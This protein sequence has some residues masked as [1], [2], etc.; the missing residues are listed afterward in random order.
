[1]Q[2]PSPEVLS[3]ETERIRSAASSATD[4]AARAELGQFLT[5]EPTARLM[6]GMF[7]AAPDRLRL[8][9]PG[10]GSGS[11]T[12]A[13][14]SALLARLRPPAA[15]HATLYEV[16]ASILPFL[17]ETLVLC[18]EAARQHGCA[19]TFEVRRS[20]FIRA[21]LDASGSLFGTPERYD[22]AVINP[23]YGKLAA[24]SAERTAMRA[25][26][27]DAPNL[28]AAFVVLAA[29]LLD[30]GGEL[31]AITPRSFANG[32]YFRAFRS[33]LFRRV[34]PRGI[35][36]FHA[37]DRAFSEDAVLQENVVLHAVRAPRA[38]EDA[39]RISASV[40]AD[41]DY[42]T[43]HDVPLSLVMPGDAD[44][45]LFL[46]DDEAAL[47]VADRIGAFTA[48]LASL[49]M[50]VS[51]GPV[52]DF[53]VAEALLME[54]AP[55]AVPLL[56]PAHL[57]G[58]R[59]TWPAPGRKPNGLARTSA[60][61][62]LLVP[63]GTYVLVKR[64]TAKE[65]A[66]R[67]VA[68]VV[69][70]EDVGG[71]DLGIENHLNYFHAGGR[72]LPQDV[73]RGL[74]AYLNSALVDD[75]FRLFSGHTQ[76]NASDLRML[77]YPSL[78]DL[79]RL[80]GPHDGS[81]KSP[82]QL[83]GELRRM[84]EGVDAQAAQEK[85][86][87]ALDVLRQLG[88]PRGQLNE[89]SAL[90][91]LALLGMGPDTPWEDASDPLVGITQAMGMFAD[92]YGR[93]YAPNTRETVRRQSVHQFL[94][95]GLIVQ[96]P[97]DPERPTNS[98]RTVYRIEAGALDLLRGYGTDEWPDRLGTYHASVGELR[99]RYA[100]EREMVRIPVQLDPATTVTLSA[101]GQNVLIK[102]IIEEFGSRFA[103]GGRV[104]YVGDADEKWMVYEEADFA[105][106]GIRVDAHGKMPDVV[107]HDAA[108]GWLFLVEAV[109]SHGP[110]DAKRRDELA[111][112]FAGSTAGLVYVT[113]F[114][115]RRT[116]M[117]YLPD[118]SWETE[119]WVAESPSHLIHFNGE[120]FMGPYP[121]P[122]A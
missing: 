97:D 86:D 115:D 20:D 51:T 2:G 116:M 40:D 45:V 73:A 31:V 91:L 113:A 118:I 42:R 62:K 120:R 12:A 7:G 3:F 110:V 49:G 13:T 67:V 99:E 46:P 17:A 35:H 111:V 121:D 69:E 117:R 84:V 112:L 52:V 9:D 21:A 30:P 48:P 26:G 74:A 105:A 82:D 24:D 38:A 43:E 8:L 28:Y 53:R 22:W 36:L 57:R 34:T 78:A 81:S 6:A 94:D 59:V 75:Y 85:I 1:M 106:L 4:R 89:R 65:E 63:S 87:E 37:R 61:S 96:N 104:L 55:G 29:D 102:Q 77:R 71:D 119:V 27:L 72:G 98:G 11:L 23:P 39:V 68:V 10:A 60:T 90:T 108:R 47:D 56:Y 44:D 80:G 83:T 88:M 95:A 64:F 114:L 58:G 19:F 92:R 33:E 50:S 25:A 32:T 103:P 76:V 18:Q 66:R 100:R 15:I 79:R 101:G 107:L 14:V 5:P 122:G 93:R 109:M 54:A 41:D 16:D 70:P